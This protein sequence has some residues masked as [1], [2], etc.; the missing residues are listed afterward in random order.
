MSRVARGRAP[1]AVLFLAAGW[2]RSRGSAQV[3]CFLTH[4]TERDARPDPARISIALAALLR[5]ITGRGPRYC[6]S[7]ED[8][9]VRFAERQRHQIFV[10]PEGLDTDW[11]YLSGLSMSL[12]AGSPGRGRPE[13]SGAGAGGD[14]PAG[15]RD[16]VR[17]RL[18]GAARRHAGG[19]GAPRAVPRRAG[20]RDLRVRGGGR[21]GAR[22]RGER[23]A[24]G[25]GA[26]ARAVHARRGTRP[27]SG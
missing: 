12:P 7:I 17:R 25:E 13:P 27:T 24:R 2:S 19:A 8:K 16:R 20:E 9:V 21:A 18:P 10:E 1:G 26:G 14:S 15:L 5:R 3:D 11:T 23:G 6:P 4:T 22:G